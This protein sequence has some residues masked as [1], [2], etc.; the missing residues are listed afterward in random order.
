MQ[1]PLNIDLQQII[2]HLFN[3]FI[4]FGGLYFLLYKPVKQFME[5]RTAY[6]EEMDAQAKAALEN[7][8]NLE[9][10]WNEKLEAVE[11]EISD[12]RRQAV[13]EAQQIGQEQKAQTELECEA[14][15][16]AAKAQ[17]VREKE[18]IINEAKEEVADIAMQAVKKLLP[19]E[20][21]DPLDAFLDQAEGK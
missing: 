3:F 6:Y 7:A 13:K 5:K 19:S 9:S 10:S 14:M 11:E 18:K 12:R 1:I 2:L 17:A 21:T 16:T 20:D 8:K 15:L 4:L